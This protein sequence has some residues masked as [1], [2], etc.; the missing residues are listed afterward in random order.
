MSRSPVTGRLLGVALSLALVGCSDNDASKSA[1]ASQN[2]GDVAAGKTVAEQQC[3]GC[4]GLD[5]KGLAPAIPSLAGQ[6]IRYLLAALAEYRDGR[7]IHAALRDI[8]TR[9]SD[10][11]TRNVAA[12]FASLPPLPVAKTEANVDSP[13]ERGKAVSVACAPCHGADG[14]SKTPGTPNLAGQQPRYIVTAVQEYLMGAREHAPMQSLVRNMSRTDL[15]DV[16]LY[17]ASQVPAQ[18]G[19][20]P[21]GVAGAGEPLTALCGGCHGAH[22][23]GDDAATPTLAAQ[24]PEYL[25]RSI[26]AYRTTRKH[27]S[28]QRAVVGLSDADIDTIAAYYS[29]QKGRPAE[30]GQRLIEDITEKCGRCHAP[31]VDNPTMAIPIISGQDRDYLVMALRSYRDDRRRS[32]VMHVMSLPYGDSVIESIATFYADQPAKT[33]QPP[34]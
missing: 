33:D 1:A 22:G 13:Y 11:D 2:A 20:A 9:L 25:V 26:K 31:N 34:K 17:F 23:V 19:A 28:M 27:P 21:F 24:D 7:R 5:G 30:D 15:E 32:S 14:N 6:R 16:A 10:S 18:R 3:K 8:A 29:V 4:H 12:Y